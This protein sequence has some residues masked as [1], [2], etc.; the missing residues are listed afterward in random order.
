MIT[1]VER[2]SLF[3][4]LYDECKDSRDFQSSRKWQTIVIYIALLTLYLGNFVTYKKNASVDTLK[5]EYI[6]S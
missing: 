6:D 3:E 1:N 2:R 5:Q 4:K